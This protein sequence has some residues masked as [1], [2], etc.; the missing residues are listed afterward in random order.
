MIGQRHASGRGLT[1][2]AARGLRIRKPFSEAEAAGGVTTRDDPRGKV[3][4]FEK[5]GPRMKGTDRNACLRV[6]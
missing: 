5:V 2:G 6:A 3:K 4:H 1:G